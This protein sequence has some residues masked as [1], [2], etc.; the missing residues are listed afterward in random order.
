M[1]R[2]IGLQG[3]RWGIVRKH[4]AGVTRV[5]AAREVTR[6]DRGTLES[7]PADVSPKETV[8]L[9][10]AHPDT[11]RS[12]KCD[13][14]GFSTCMR[15]PLPVAGLWSY[16]APA[17]RIEALSRRVSSAGISSDRREVDGPYETHS[18][19]TRTKPLA[20]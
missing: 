2:L 9:T 12:K 14:G 19:S 17:R 1:R 4:A 6:T 18:T 11:T 20:V 13:V 7:A 3:S 15:L 5:Q 10:R 16:G 8:A